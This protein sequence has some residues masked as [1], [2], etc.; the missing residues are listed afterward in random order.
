MRLESYKLNDS[1]DYKLNIQLGHKKTMDHMLLYGPDN[2][3]SSEWKT[4]YYPI[5][6]YNSAYLYLVTPLFIYI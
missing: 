1:E 5:F 3:L 4:I 6:N 2:I